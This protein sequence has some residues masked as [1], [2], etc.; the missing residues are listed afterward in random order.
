MLLALI[1]GHQQPKPAVESATLSEVCIV[2][3]A[4]QV[5]LGWIL[6]G[7]STADISSGEPG[8]DV[9]H[10]LTQSQSGHVI[11]ILLILSAAVGM[12]FWSTQDQ[13]LLLSGMAQVISGNA[14]AF[15]P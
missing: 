3:D 1:R 12:T 2:E 5:T 4:A 13:H 9:G 10:L 8:I 15:N 6:L 7:A 11:L 14:E